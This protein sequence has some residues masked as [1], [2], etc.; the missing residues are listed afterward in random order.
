MYT[1]IC[2]NDRELADYFVARLMLQ[3]FAE[4]CYDF[5]KAFE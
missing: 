4:C 3:E 2:Q 5:V 1:I